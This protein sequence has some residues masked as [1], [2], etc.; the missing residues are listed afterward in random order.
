MC[1]SF[2]I[3]CRKLALFGSQLRFLARNARVACEKGF[4]H[5][6]VPD[7]LNGSGL[8]RVPVRHQRPGKDGPDGLIGGAGRARKQ[9]SHH[10]KADRDKKVPDYLFPG[11][12]P[13]CCFCA[14][15]TCP[16]TRM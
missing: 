6:H 8:R 9:S 16:R 5:E 4:P 12:V 3:S 1:L 2:H 14:F 7:V 13:I 15:P 10:L 11:S